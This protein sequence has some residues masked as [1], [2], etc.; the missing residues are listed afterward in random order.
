[1]FGGFGFRTDVG[2][3]S[4]CWVLLGRSWVLGDAGIGIE[5]FGVTG[6]RERVETQN[7][8]CDFDEVAGK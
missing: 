7:P 2:K 6:R 5:R 1:M 4:S 3:R 8:E